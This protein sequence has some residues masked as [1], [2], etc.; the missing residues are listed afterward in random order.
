MV[1]SK[2]QSPAK[3]RQQTESNAAASTSTGSCQAGFQC[4]G[5]GAGKCIRASQ[6]CDGVADC[7]D[8][9][10]EK[11]CEC[12]YDIKISLLTHVLMRFIQQGVIELLATR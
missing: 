8:K 10:D 5:L 12:N 3:V 7:S 9:S 6:V 4:S 2:S 11:N 1:N